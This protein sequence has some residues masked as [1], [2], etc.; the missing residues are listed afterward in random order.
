MRY[1]PAKKGPPVS[2]GE[3]IGVRAATEE[4]KN[5]YVYTASSGQKQ[6]DATLWQFNTATEKAK[7]IGTV[8]VGDTSYIASLDVDLTGR[9]LYYVPGA[10]GGGYRDGSPLVQFDVKNGKKKV[11]AFLHPFYQEK[12]AFTPK[13]TYS[14]AV[15]PEGDK[16]YI[17]WNVSR[18]TRA[19]D[20]CGLTVVHI[21]ASERTP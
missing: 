2:I 5:G 4:T 17:T 3:T 7:K 12:Y 9:Y 16:V 13:G 21:P 11:I 18:G 20:C 19:W 15:S 10:H 6:Q 14:T 1:D 8:S